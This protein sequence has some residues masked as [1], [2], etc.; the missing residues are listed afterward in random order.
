MKWELRR[1]LVQRS[2][3]RVP[4]REAPKVLAVG[5]VRPLH[6][7]F[8][9]VIHGIATVSCCAASRAAVRLR[10]HA[11]ESICAALCPVAGHPEP[12]LR[13][14]L[15]RSLDEPPRIDELLRLPSTVR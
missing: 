8:S 1:Q 2:G 9:K 4:T 15:V 11:A 10:E 3:G 5:A 7:D 12:A 6:I 14:S 13:Q